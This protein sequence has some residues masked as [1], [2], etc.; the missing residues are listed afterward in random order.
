MSVA[1]LV[2]VRAFHVQIATGDRLREM[3]EDQHLR[4]LRVSPR[5]GAIYDRHGAELAV[6]ADVDSV[7]ANPRRLKAMEQDPQT[8]ARRIAKVLDVDY[9]RLAKRL[10]ADR[11]FVWIERQVTPN[12]ATRIRELDIP[13][14]ELMT[15]PT[16]TG[17]ASRA[18]SSPTRT[19]FGA[20]ID[21]SRRFA[22]G[23]VTSSLRTTWKM[24]ARS[25]GR[26]W[27]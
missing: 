24:I 20:R 16:S 15:E 8:V 23:A 2:I 26:A 14:I 22:I 17:E 7:Y 11:Y 27:C 10:A 3:A 6:S 1:L 13:G 9:E 5:R 18:S 12:E 19:D 21:G 25:K 4:H